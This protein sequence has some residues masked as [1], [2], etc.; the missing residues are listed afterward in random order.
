MEDYNNEVM[1]N[2]TDDVEVITDVE[3]LDDEDVQ[4]GGVPAVVPIAIGAAA[5]AGVTAL[6]IKVGPKIGRKIKNGA[7]N[8]KGKLGRKKNHD[9]TEIDPGNSD[10]KD[11]K[12][13][14]AEAKEIQ[15]EE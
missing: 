2:N 7:A 5:V 4:Q 12:T 9:Y 13:I 11:L 10:V 14:A 6:V 1:E 3:I 15:G 8:L